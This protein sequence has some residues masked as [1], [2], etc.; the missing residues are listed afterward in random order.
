MA[1]SRG[2]EPLEHLRALLFSGQVQ[3][4]AL[5]T[6][7]NNFNKAQIDQ[8]KSL[9][10]IWLLYA[11]LII[12]LTGIQFGGSCRIRTYEPKKGGLQSAV[13]DYFAKFLFINAQIRL[14]VNNTDRFMQLQLLD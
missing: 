4:A 8:I 3:L 11:P 14:S 6:L 7:Q 9:L 13:V 10:L 5:P 2:F 1:E 12:S